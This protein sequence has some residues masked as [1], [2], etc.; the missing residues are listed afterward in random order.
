M[1]AHKRDIRVDRV[2]KGKEAQE[3]AQ[4]QFPIAFDEF[5]AVSKVD[6]GELKSAYDRIQDAF[7]RS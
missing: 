4:S 5:L 6:M 1:G 2:E 3:E 7:D